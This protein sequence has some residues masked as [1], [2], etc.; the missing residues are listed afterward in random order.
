MIAE[1]HFHEITWKLDT[2]KT[3]RLTGIGEYSNGWIFF[4]NLFQEC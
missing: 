3:E 2:G 1:I 4:N